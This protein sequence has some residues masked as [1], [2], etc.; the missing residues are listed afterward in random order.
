MI[1]VKPVGLANLM[2]TKHKMGRQL[3]IVASQYVV[4]DSFTE[5]NSGLCGLRLSPGLATGCLNS[6][7]PYVFL[8]SWGNT[9]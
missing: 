2:F 1:S 6:L 5:K 9:I 8:C 7:P 3:N 4:R